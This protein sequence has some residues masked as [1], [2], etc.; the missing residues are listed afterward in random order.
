VYQALILALAGVVRYAFIKARGRIAVRSP[1]RMT[2]RRRH[3]PASRR[4]EQTGG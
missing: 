2:I 4:D 3:P 1:P